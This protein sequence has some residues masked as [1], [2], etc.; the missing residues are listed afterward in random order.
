MGH[1]N[2]EYIKKIE[3]YLDHQGLTFVPLREEMI[4]HLIGD[5][6]NHIEQGES[7]DEAWSIISNDIPENHFITL[8]KETM[9]AIN[10]RFNI[11][12]GFTYL[13]IFLLTIT[14]QI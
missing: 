6:E 9:E 5:L 7:F 1:I 3:T 8:Q 2:Q 12:K 10:K 13:S 4:D 11:S 14:S